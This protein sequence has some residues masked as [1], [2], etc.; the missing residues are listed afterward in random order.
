M[1][2]G[3]SWSAATQLAGPM[4][5]SWLPD[6]SEGLMFG[7]YIATAVLAGGKAYPVFPVSSV[8]TGSTL[9]QAMDAP[10]GGLPVTGGSR[11][12]TDRPAIATAPR[13]RPATVP[14]TAR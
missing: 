13:Y 10:A 12:A 11:I 4:K 8:P 2:G 9:H 14:L 7:D 5:L 1:N 3:A 6:T